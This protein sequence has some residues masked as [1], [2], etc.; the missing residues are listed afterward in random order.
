MAIVTPCRYR[1]ER[2]EK[3]WAFIH[4]R[5]ESCKFAGHNVAVMMIMAA[6]GGFRQYLVVGGGGGCE[7]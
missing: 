3:G 4:R 5:G 1:E 6:K 7:G 2:K